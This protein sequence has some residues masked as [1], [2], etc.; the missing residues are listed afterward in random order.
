MALTDSAIT[1]PVVWVD[2]RK[3]NITS[4]HNPSHFCYSK[5]FRKA[6]AAL[7]SPTSPPHRNEAC[8]SSGCKGYLRLLIGNVNLLATAH[9]TAK[10]VYCR[11]L[12]SWNA[13]TM[14]SLGTP[15]R[16]NSVAIPSSVQSS[17]IQN[18]PS[19]IRT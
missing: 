16:T 5:P 4:I 9:T 18:F 15:A 13:K 19:R 10:S 8:L 12:G 14:S 3:S 6:I 7:S 1:H 2:V 11:V 17:S